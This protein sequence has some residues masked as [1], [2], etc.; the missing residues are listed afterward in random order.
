MNEKLKI[1]L[2]GKYPPSK[3]GSASANYWLA[4]TLGDVGHEVYVVTDSCK[5]GS[6]LETLSNEQLKDYEPSGVKVFSPELSYVPRILSYMPYAS[7]L[8][9]IVIDVIKKYDIDI[10]DSK[11]LFPYC[12]AG[13][14]AK[15]VT[16][17]PLV[18][19]HA[20]SDI[21]YLMRDK[22]L[23]ILLREVLKNADKITTDPKKI[24]ELS[25]LG[26]SKDK[27][28]FETG[29]GISHKFFSE[30]R[31]ADLVPH[32]K[33]KNIPILTSIGKMHK[34]KGVVELIQ[35]ASLLGDIDFIL[36]F[37]TETEKD[38]E[39]V[40][41]YI[42]K[43]NLEEKTMFLSYQPPWII[44]SIYKASTC[45]VCAEHDHPVR[46]HTPLAA[47]EALHTGTCVIISEE[48]FGKQPFSSFEAEKSIVVVNPKNIKKFSDKLRDLLLNPKKTQMIGNKASKMYFEQDPE[49]LT[50]IYYELIRR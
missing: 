1:C 32:T 20:G 24:E 26:I 4:R 48:T 34:Y 36:L 7:I 14:I 2:I 16:K 21:T 9:A 50:K 3:G 13:F 42:R 45:L 6:Y 15:V 39:Y 44:P 29:F 38:K 10:I 35:A 11:Y 25:K 43:Y 5:D 37:V 12:W 40:E 17:R 18:V 46:F 22:Y 8:A 33:R 49:K 27:F 41:D 23:G 31:P 47:I 30:A 19:R 28:I